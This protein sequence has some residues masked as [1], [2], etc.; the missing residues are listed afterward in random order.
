MSHSCCVVKKMGKKGVMRE[1]CIDEWNYWE[2]VAVKG[3]LSGESFRN[4]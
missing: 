4:G 1:G 3:K 2:I